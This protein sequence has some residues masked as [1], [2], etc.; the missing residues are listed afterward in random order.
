MIN[1]LYALSSAASDHSLRASIASLGFI[2]GGVTMPMV[3]F[4]ASWRTGFRY[5]FFIP[6]GALIIAVIQTLRIGPP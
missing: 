4:L 6:V 3:C 1:V 5:L 2:I